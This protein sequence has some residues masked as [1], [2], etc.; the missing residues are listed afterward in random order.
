[1]SE[2]VLRILGLTKAYGQRPPALRDVH[3]EVPPGVTGLLGPNGAG[4]STLL[5]CILGLLPDFTGDAEVLGLDARR[6][7]R[8]IRRKV[9][10]MPELDAY[11]YGVTGLRAVRY[12]AQ[13]SGL[14]RR[15]ALRRAHEVLWHVG[16]GEAIYR[17]VDGYSTGMRQ[18]F[19][20]AQAIVHDPALVFLDEPLAG[21]DPDGR[22]DVRA[23]IHDL[24]TQHGKH[25]VWS[26]HLLPDVQRVAEQ[27]VVLHRG[28]SRGLF[29]MDELAPRVGRFRVEVEGDGQGLCDI[30]AAIEDGAVRVE[31]REVHRAG[32]QVVERA[33]IEIVG[34]KDLEAGHLL[35][36]GHHAGVRMRRVLPVSETLEDVF[37][38]LLGEEPGTPAG[39]TP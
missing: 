5:Q 30:L 13:L 9:G 33:E 8:A 20:L 27:V 2:P 3:L 18:R 31:R 10:F 24:A 38:R 25:I 17:T 28:Q 26:S 21:L 14:P 1:M 6:Q 37:L 16:L 22:K 34:P 29:R 15:E 19:K 32:S 23:L 36:I 39:S 12:L 11:L 4:K 35:A 7:R